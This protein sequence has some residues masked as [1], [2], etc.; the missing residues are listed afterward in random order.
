MERLSAQSLLKSVGASGQTPITA[1]TPRHGLTPSGGLTSQEQAKARAW[2]ATRKPTETDQAIRHSLTSQLGVSVN[3]KREWRY[4]EGKPPYQV[5]IS[6][7]ILAQSTDNVRLAIGKVEFASVPPSHEEAELM[8][9]QLQQALAR[10]A[11]SEDAAEVGFDAYVH[12]LRRHPLDVAQAAV[13]ELANEPRPGNAAAWFPTLPELEGVCR[14]YGG[15]REA[16]LD[17]L[18]G[19][20]EPSPEAVE[21][22]RLEQEWKDL[23]QR[24]SELNMKVGP[25]PATD[26]GP[27]GERLAAARE[28]EQQ[29]MKAR[30]AFLAA[31]KTTQHHN[32]NNF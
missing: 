29:S 16:M 26:T 5:T 8:V 32:A 23:R 12:C 14:K 28:A 30:E 9:S 19:W 27:R 10:R 3:V 4:P 17:A 1:L 2:L 21:V 15:D 31:E 20:R 25:G 7:G 6:A 22:R 11:S 13:M 18:R 24:A